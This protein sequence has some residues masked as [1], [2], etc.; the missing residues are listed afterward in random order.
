MEI[1]L[2]EHKLLAGFRNYGLVFFLVINFCITNH[3]KYSSSSLPKSQ[4]QKL[5]DLLGLQ[6]G[7]GIISLLL[8]SVE[9]G[10][11]QGQ[12]QE[13]LGMGLHK[14]MSAERHGS[15]WATKLMGHHNGLKNFQWTLHSPYLTQCLAC[16]RFSVNIC[17]MTAPAALAYAAHISST[18][19]HV[20][21][22]ILK[23]KSEQLPAKSHV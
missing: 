21:V 12:I 18:T 4:K 20:E 23:T 1:C 2:R 15:L 19:G 16:S 8:Y 17:Q 9:A 3:S 7:T 6:S 5:P 10:H 11:I 13:R 22:Q 14:G